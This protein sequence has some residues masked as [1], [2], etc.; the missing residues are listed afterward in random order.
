VIGRYA[1]GAGRLFVASAFMKWGLSS[2]T[3]A[4]IILA[5]LIAG[6][7]NAWADR[8]SPTRLSLRSA[9]E[10]AQMNSKVGL[11][12][13]GDRLRPAAA[14]SAAAVP[15][16]AARVVRDG[17]GKTGVYRDEDG[18]VHAVSLRCTHLGCLLRFN[19][20]ERSWDCPCHGSRFDVDG[21]VLEGPAVDPLELRTPP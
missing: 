7:E 5:D 14:G 1:P 2:G 3:F 18:K 13:I 9:P 6:R 17:L 19:S 15:R 11:D 10:L 21:A 12:F 20:A 4:A 8:F 16:G